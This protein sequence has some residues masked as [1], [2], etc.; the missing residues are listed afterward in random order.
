MIKI[1][2]FRKT[3]LD[4]V[5]SLCSMDKGGSTPGLGRPFC[6]DWSDKVRTCLAGTYECIVA[7]EDED[8]VAFGAY[9]KNSGTLAELAGINVR[10][11]YMEKNLHQIMM[12]SMEERAQHKG[13]KGFC[14]KS[15]GRQ[16]ATDAMCRDL[17]FS[18]VHCAEEN[19]SYTVYQ[20]YF[21]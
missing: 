13:F 16:P 12:Y 20:K 21:G 7:E 18:S 3:D 1:R 19:S 6:P 11:D 17:G 15:E 4:Q 8:V 2:A 9:S 10:P 5:K 14:M